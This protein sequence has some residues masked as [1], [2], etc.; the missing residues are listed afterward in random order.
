MKK[1]LTKQ[2]RILYTSLDK[3]SNQNA[4]KSKKEAHFSEIGKGKSDNFF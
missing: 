1:A 2:G 3:A 4:A